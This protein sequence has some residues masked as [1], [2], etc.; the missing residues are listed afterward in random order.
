MRN[1]LMDVSLTQALLLRAGIDAAAFED[2]C[3]GDRHA[4]RRPRQG[5]AH[6][7]AR[8]RARL[9]V[10]EGALELVAAQMRAHQARE[11]P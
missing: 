8:H 6:L 4:L 10:R 2:R 11:R 3:G 5:A 7:Q 9:H 1:Q